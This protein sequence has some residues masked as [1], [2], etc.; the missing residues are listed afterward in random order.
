[1]NMTGLFSQASNVLHTVAQTTEEQFPFL[2][3][4]REM[5]NQRILSQLKKIGLASRSEVK[6]LKTRI[7]HLEK[8]I[9]LLK[10]RA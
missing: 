6:A 8:E 3:N 9:E 1:M 5:A 4:R 7:E 10:K 2:K